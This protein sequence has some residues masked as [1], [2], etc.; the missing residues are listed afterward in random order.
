MKTKRFSL[1]F[2]LLLNACAAPAPVRT[3]IAVAS[4]T[5]APLA[6]PASAASTQ[7]QVQAPTPM[8]VKL[9]LRPVLIP[10]YMQTQRLRYRPDPST[11]REYPNAIWAERLEVGLT[12]ALGDALHQQAPDWRICLQACETTST[13]SSRVLRVEFTAL[14]AWTQHNLLTAHAKWT[15]TAPKS[16]NPTTQEA[17]FQIPLETDTPAALGNA[18]GVL[19]RQLGNSVLTSF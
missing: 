12:R 17:D 3:L 8:P 11:V 7:M 18:M 16:E 10:E 13:P 1:M 19:A 14:D 15:W 6:A 9:V 2:A 5:A 4:P